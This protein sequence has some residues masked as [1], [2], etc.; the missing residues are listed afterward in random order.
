MFESFGRSIVVESS[1]SLVAS[2]STPVGVGLPIPDFGH[3]H[4]TRLTYLVVFA[5]DSSSGDGI[6][7]IAAVT[8][9]VYVNSITSIL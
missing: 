4:V 9:P 1:W 6:N 8:I 3:C 7:D 5:F 2:K